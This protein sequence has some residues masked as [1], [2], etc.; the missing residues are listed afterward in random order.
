MNRGVLV[1]FEG[2]EGSGKTTQA[3]FLYHDL[4]QEGVPSILLREPGG[5]KIGERIREL[6]LDPDEEISPWAELFLYL[7]ARTELIE[8]KISPALKAHKVIILDRY[9]DSTYAYQVY[10]RELPYRRVSLLNRIATR[11]IKPDITILVDIS[12]S[13]GLKRLS[14]TKDRIEAENQNYHTRVRA[15]YLK[16][17]SRAKKRIRLMDGTLAKEDLHQKIKAIIFP[18]LRKKGYRL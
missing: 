6:L 3:E 17:A 10:G 16:I 13:Q 9:I 5:T 18:F 15:G 2:I 12:T 4:S 1:S 14:E 7:A 11:A 8:G